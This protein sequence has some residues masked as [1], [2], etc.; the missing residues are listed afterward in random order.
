MQLEQIHRSTQIK[1]L[2]LNQF[3]FIGKTGVSCTSVATGLLSIQMT[4]RASVPVKMENKLL[5]LNTV[6]FLG[7]SD[8]KH[9]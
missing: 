8:Q 3:S 5:Y 2:T 6:H 9:A 4:W 7:Q 1:L